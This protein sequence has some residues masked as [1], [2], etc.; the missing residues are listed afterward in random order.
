MAEERLRKKGVTQIRAAQCLLNAC[1][2]GHLETVRDILN[3][4]WA[5]A[6]GAVGES[7]RPLLVAS[8]SGNL[9]IVFE[10]LER[11]ANPNKKCNG[12][13]PLTGALE[14]RR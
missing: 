7:G 10:L 2:Q 4:G 9:D 12:E 1:T 3:L 8:L 6:D 5:S 14:R 11:G 13:Y